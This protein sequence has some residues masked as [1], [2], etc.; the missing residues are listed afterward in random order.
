MENK[1]PAWFPA[2]FCRTSVGREGG[3]WRTEQLEF[4]TIKNTHCVSSASLILPLLVLSLP[5]DLI[6]FPKNLHWLP[7]EKSFKYR[8]LTLQL[9]VLV[10]LI[11][12]QCPNLSSPCYS[13]WS[14]QEGVTT[15]TKIIGFWEERQKNKAAV[16]IYSPLRRPSILLTAKA[17]LPVQRLHSSSMSLLILWFELSFL[18]L[19]Y[20]LLSLWHIQCYWTQLASTVVMECS[21]SLSSLN[22]PACPLA[23]QRNP[24]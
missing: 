16:G 17:F 9:Q 11:L 8:F 19:T 7:T 23:T 14:S 22:V 13:K 15:E 6:G 5:R 3:N 21:Q 2:L 12:S 18:T 10:N 20:L 24:P 1:A 4:V